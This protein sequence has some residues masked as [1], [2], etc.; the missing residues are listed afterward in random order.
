M[1]ALKIEGSR[2]ETDYKVTCPIIGF[3]G[4]GEAVNLASI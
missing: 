4:P 3:S 1:T 2:R